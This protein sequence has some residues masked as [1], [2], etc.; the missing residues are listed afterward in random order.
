MSVSG[1]MR[2][3]TKVCVNGSVTAGELVTYI[4]YYL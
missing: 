2:G 4:S 1:G 3:I